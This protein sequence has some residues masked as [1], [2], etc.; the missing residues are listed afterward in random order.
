M[1]NVFSHLLGQGDSEPYKDFSPMFSSPLLL[2][3]AVFSRCS[4]ILE[5]HYGKVWRELFAICEWK[6]MLYKTL[7]RTAKC[8]TKSYFK[9]LA[10]HIFIFLIFPKKWILVKSKMA[11]IFTAIM[12]G[13]SDP[14]HRH[15]PLCLSYLVEH[16][17]CIT[18]T[19]CT[20][21]G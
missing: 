12:D 11:A 20:S 13:I 3:H 8:F 18:S 1:W 21:E 7:P 2:A 10:K 19:P 4:F 17:T 15:T 16:I 5:T 6:C 9:T 14:Q